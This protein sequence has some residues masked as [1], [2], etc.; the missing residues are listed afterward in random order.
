LKGDSGN[1]Q[2]RPGAINSDHGRLGFASDPIMSDL[3]V[4]DSLHGKKP[5]IKYP[6][7]WGY[8][9]IGLDEQALRAAVH[10]CLPDI[11]PQLTVSRTSASGKY[12]SLN[13][14]VTVTDETH[15]N[16]VFAALANHVDI[17]LVI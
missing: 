17:R 14:T 9:V 5:D 16:A 4:M 7:P 10:D 13:L 8:K 15:R 6:C 11:D 12:V 1:V 2:E 3:G